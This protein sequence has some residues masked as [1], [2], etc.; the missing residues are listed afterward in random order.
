MRRHTSYIRLWKF[1]VFACWLIGSVPFWL[2]LSYH[3]SVRLSR[4]P[5]S[6]IPV[7]DFLLWRRPVDRLVASKHTWRFLWQGTEALCQQPL[8]KWSPQEAYINGFG[9]WFPVK[10]WDTAALLGKLDVTWWEILTQK[11]AAKFFPG[12][13]PCE[14]MRD[15]QCVSFLASTLWDKFYPAIH[16]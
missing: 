5:F 11:T 12:S 6:P 16:S 8:G 14:I 10:L 1:W 3:S 13:W 15:N 9:S 4:F 2:C 7:S